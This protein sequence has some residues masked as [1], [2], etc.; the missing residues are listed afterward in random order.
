MPTLLSTG[1]APAETAS[2]GT[3]ANLAEIGIDDSAHVPAQLA[4][5]LVAASTVVVAMKPGLDIPQVD[6]VTYE[7]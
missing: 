6:S 5:D 1:V 7:T 3:M 2:A 4:E